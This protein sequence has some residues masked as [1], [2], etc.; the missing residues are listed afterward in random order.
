MTEP[1]EHRDPSLIHSS[2]S[3]V[4]STTSIF[5]DT[6]SVYFFELPVHISFSYGGFYLLGL[7]LLFIHQCYIHKCKK[8]CNIMQIA[9]TIWSKKGI[10][11]EFLVHVYDTAT[12]IGVLVQWSILA[13]D[14]NDYKSIDMR[15]MLWLSIMIHLIYRLV[16]FSWQA[17]AAKCSI[18]KACCAFF[19]VYII[20]TVWKSIIKNEK[21]ASPEQR[22]ILLCEAVFEAFPQV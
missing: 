18:S 19:D 12:D 10:Y 7:L 20:K 1:T 4:T 16:L 14:K 17:K 3:F 9:S 13:Y 2:T 6:A 11:L 5:N 22:I 21:E 15:Y 8:C